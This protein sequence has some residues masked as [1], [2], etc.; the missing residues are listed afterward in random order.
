MVTG[1]IG[2]ALSTWM[3]TIPRLHTFYYFIHCNNIQ[4]NLSMFIF[5]DEL[6]FLMRW[7]N[8]LYLVIVASQVQ[9]TVS[10]E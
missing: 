1:T 9:T 2:K 8:G 6:A 4:Y 10:M 5:M 7:D 3:E